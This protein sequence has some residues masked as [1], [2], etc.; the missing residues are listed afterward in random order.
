MKIGIWGYFGY[1]N[2]GDD[3]L[4]LILNEHLQRISDDMNQIRVFGEKKNVKA[5]LPQEN[6][7]AEKRTAFSALH[8]AF[9]VDLFLVGP[10]GI[11][12]STNTRK[13][14][15][16]LILTGIMK[17]RKKRIGFIGVGIG[18]GMFQRKADI[19]LI[20]KIAELA[21]TFVSRSENYLNFVPELNEKNILLASDMVFTDKKQWQRSENKS[22]KLVVVALADVFASNTDE[23]KEL[24]I[25]EIL[26]FFKFILEKGY[27]IHLIPFTN[28]IDEKFQNEI[29]RRLVSEKIKSIP[30]QE[31]PYATCQEISKGDLCIGMR[32]HALVMSF[33]MGIPAMSISYSDKNEDLM[34]RFGLGGYSVRFGISKKEYYNEE[35]MIDASNLISVF[36]TMERKKEDIKETIVSHLPE[37]KEQSERNIREL[38]KL[39]R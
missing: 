17:L 29:C 24:F 25:E 9:R 23:Y 33:M 31:D 30:Y 28:E 32:F 35:I 22:S 27:F 26:L 19:F 7:S 16:Y 11:F 3:L 10:G 37:I 5:L 38:E 12:P 8:S 34:Q 39:L 2:C 1:R 4:L 21:D 15:F 36:E 18:T 13:L 6:V 20:N 14:F